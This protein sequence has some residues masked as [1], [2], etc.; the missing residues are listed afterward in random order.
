MLADEETG[1]PASRLASVVLSIAYLVVAFEA[2]GVEGALRMLLFC[3]VP[4]ACIW[5]PEG[6]PRP[7]LKFSGGSIDILRDVLR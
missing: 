5:F 4:V 2:G 6:L 1:K 7:L 3:L